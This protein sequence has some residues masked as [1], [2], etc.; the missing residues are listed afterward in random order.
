[1]S[2][3]NNPPKT[4]PFLG[5]NLPE[6]EEKIT[7]FSEALAAEKVQG[8]IDLYTAF[9]LEKPTAQTEE[10]KAAFAEGQKALQTLKAIQELAGV[11]SL[12]GAPHEP[13][14]VEKRLIADQEKLASAAFSDASANITSIAPDFPVEII[15]KLP[16]STSDK[17]TVM[18]AMRSVAQNGVDAVNKIKKEL[19]S[20]NS[21]EGS[22]GF[23]A[24]ET[25]SQNSGTEGQVSGKDVVA[26]FAAVSGLKINE[27]NK[28]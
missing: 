12:N 15:A 22:P 5:L 11:K 24:T 21:G 25:E 9:S 27:E 2:N 17:V 4:N 19:D 13:T 23:T 3:E 8:K 16:I 20:K 10:E 14:E 28:K 26:K 18:S 7:L 1:M 6:L